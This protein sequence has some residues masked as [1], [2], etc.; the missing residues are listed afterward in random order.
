MLINCNTAFRLERFAAPNNNALL[1]SNAVYFHSVHDFNT[2]LFTESTKY[3]VNPHGGFHILTHKDSSKILQDLNSRR[4]FVPVCSV[5]SHIICTLFVFVLA[6][7]ALVIIFAIDS[8]NLIF[9]VR[10]SLVQEWFYYFSSDQEN[11]VLWMYPI[12]WCLSVRL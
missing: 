7:L 2:Q 9:H 4:A 11:K 12:Y 5:I 10:F 6:C 1:F 3:L 8:S